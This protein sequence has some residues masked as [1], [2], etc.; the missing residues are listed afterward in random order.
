MRRASR[1]QA[2]VL[3]TRSFIR[4]YLH[5][6]PDSSQDIRPPL[7]PMTSPRGFYRTRLHTMAIPRACSSPS[8]SSCETY[9]HLVPPPERYTFTCTTCNKTSVVNSAYIEPH[10]ITFF[11]SRTLHCF[12]CKSVGDDG[13]TLEN[14]I[15]WQECGWK[16]WC[17]EEE[18][19][20]G[21]MAKG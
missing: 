9:R 16:C 19:D 3:Q 2:P 10:P 17:C 15:T 18:E 14:I 6:L 11:Q 1:R 13:L 4:Q 12:G 21:K 20:E 7:S 5:L 8:S